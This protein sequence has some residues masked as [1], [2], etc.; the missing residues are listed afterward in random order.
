MHCY[1]SGYGS[2]S[3]GTAPAVQQA[4]ICCADHC[5]GKIK[6]NPFAEGARHDIVS[7]ALRLVTAEKARLFWLISDD[8]AA[9]GGDGE[10]SAAAA[11][12]AA[13]MSCILGWYGIIARR[14][15]VLWTDAVICACVWRH[16]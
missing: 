4:Q 16:P 7:C 13:F 14:I 8:A 11:A 6:E 3:P 1:S 12:A 2:Y 15:C 9:V 10:V 5:V